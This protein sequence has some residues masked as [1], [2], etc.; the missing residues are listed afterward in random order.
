MHKTSRIILDSTSVILDNSSVILDSSWCHI[1]HILRVTKIKKTKKDGLLDNR[2]AIVPRDPI[3]FLQKK[4]EMKMVNKGSEETENQGGYIKIPDHIIRNI[5]NPRGL[6][7]YGLIQTLTHGGNIE[8]KEISQSRFR[9]IHVSHSSFDK[10]IDELVADFKI[11]K[12]CFG[13]YNFN[14]KSYKCFH[15]FQTNSYS[16]ED[17]F[18]NKI[19]FAFLISNA[20]PELKLAYIIFRS[21]TSDKTLRLQNS[22]AEI[23]SS[24]KGIRRSTMMS[25]W[26]LL[27]EKGCIDDE[28]GDMGNKNTF[29]FRFNYK[30]L[31]AMYQGDLKSFMCIQGVGKV[32]YEKIDVPIERIPIPLKKKLSTSK[33]KKKSTKNH[34]WMTGSSDYWVSS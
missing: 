15:V 9:N 7:A 4:T 24:V 33:P 32:Q 3:N 12:P 16:A 34:D 13:K 5:K 21:F 19:P 26:K 22:L 20:S 31:E 23:C 29:G 10:V 6:F 2:S 1:G 18:V 30:R 11:P 17:Y 8:D 27:K 14:K 25:Y 28:Y